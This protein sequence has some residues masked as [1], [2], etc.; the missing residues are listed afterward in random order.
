MDRGMLERHLKLAKEHVARGAAVVQRQRE[1][2]G[3]LERDG[4]D[5]SDARRL[6]AAFETQQDMHVTGLARVRKEIDELR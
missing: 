2:L 1:L 4:H 5:T 6:L 3:E